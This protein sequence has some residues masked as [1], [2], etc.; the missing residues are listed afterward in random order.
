VSEE[1]YIDK[2]KRQHPWRWAWYGICMRVSYWWGW[3]VD[4]DMVD[5]FRYRTKRKNRNTENP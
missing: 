3:I 5:G 4:W 2:I 1:S